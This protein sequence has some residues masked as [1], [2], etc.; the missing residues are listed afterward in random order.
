MCRSLG[1]RTSF[2][3]MPAK[4]HPFLQT[5][6]TTGNMESD[7]QPNDSAKAVELRRSD[8]E[9]CYTVMTVK[10]I[11]LADCMVMVLMMILM[12]KKNELIKR[13]KGLRFKA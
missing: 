4:C 7:S 11:R 2:F 9:V 8:S 10:L 1:S 3:P 5:D 13:M 6:R 12:T